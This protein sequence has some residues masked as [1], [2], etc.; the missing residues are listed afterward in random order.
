VKYQAS[1]TIKQIAIR[2]LRKSS[3]FV[4]STL[5]HFPSSFSL[6]LSPIPSNAHCSP[7]EE[8]EETGHKFPLRHMYINQSINTPSRNTDPWHLLASSSSR[9]KPTRLPACL[10]DKSF[11]KGKKESWRSKKSPLN[12]NKARSEHG[13]LR[14]D[15]AEILRWGGEHYANEGRNR[16]GSIKPEVVMPSQIAKKQSMEIC[17]PRSDRKKFAREV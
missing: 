15:N 8:E 5:L 3:F 14:I 4:L 1:T 10:E 13:I 9:E 11:C 17:T 12:A 2:Y 6:F 7:E 16:R